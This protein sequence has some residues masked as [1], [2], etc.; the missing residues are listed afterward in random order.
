MHY[1]KNIKSPQD[2]KTLSEE[3]LD[4]LACDIRS[5]IIEKVS[6]TGGH[7]ASNLGVVEL[8]IALHY[9]LDSP[10]D[11]IIWDVGHQS[12]IHKILTGRWQQFDT[13]RQFN[14]LSGFPKKEENPHDI[15]DA[16][17]SS[18]SISVGL[19]IAKARDIKK[20]EFSVV[21]IIGDGALTGGIA[22]EALNNAGHINSNFIIIVNDNEMS[23]SK[24]IGGISSHLTNLRT[25]PVYA[26]AKK[27]IKTLLNKIPKAGNTIYSGLE[28]IRDAVKYALVSGVVFEELGYTYLGPID[29]HN[30][31][32]LNSVLKHAKHV[33]GPV[34]I[35][36][37][38]KK[39]KGY[40]NAE[41]EPHKFHGIGPFNPETGKIKKV[42]KEASYSKVFGDKLVE[43]AN[44]D[45]RIV[46]ITAAM[47]DGTGLKPFSVKY[48]NRFFDVGIAEQHAVTFAAGLA[49]NGMKPVVPIYSTFLQRAYDEI[50]MDICLQNLPVVLCIDRS[51]VVGED[52]ETHHGIYGISYLSHMPNL[53]ILAPKD[54]KELESMMEYALSLDQPCAI[55]YP[56]GKANDLSHVSQEYSITGKAEILVEG[57]DICL[58]AVGRMVENAY[59]AAKRLKEK[60][61][62]ATVIN[63]RFIKPLDETTLLPVLKR[64]QKIITIEDN[65][66]IGGVG[67]RIAS[68]IQNHQ[69]NI[70][71]MSMSWPDEFIQH[72]SIK[73]L[74]EEYG[75]SVKAI[76]NNVLE[77]NG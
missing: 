33:N 1:I 25:A 24:N 52:G 34:I 74:D 76:V 5:F 57:T 15:F 45:E 72:G 4:L 43:L 66:Y 18:N 3:E 9:V 71:Q 13:L 58:I 68:M 49:I 10:K 44:R 29:G 28:K 16:G 50:I 17:H 37:I 65:T 46:A 75:L 19:G 63:L 70:K 77:M 14:G 55:M 42:D 2:I 8:S 62:S 59:E 27:K 47:A 60:N 48:P 39:G 51:G 53:V 12:Y 6:K 30:I 61:I 31:K 26:Q 20:E 38:T 11:K 54:G 21:S 32:E 41:K 7:L 67:D 69:L 36:T 22:F 56:R 23:I 40:L 64:T 35:H 73:E